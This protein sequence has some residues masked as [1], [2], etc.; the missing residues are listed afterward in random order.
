M[1][2]EID[3]ETIPLALDRL[4]RL[5]ETASNDTVAILGEVLWGPSDSGDSSRLVDTQEKK[6]LL[7]SRKLFK[8]TGLAV[9]S[10]I[11]SELSEVAQ[12]EIAEPRLDLYNEAFPLW[13]MEYLLWL[14]IHETPLSSFQVSSL[15]KAGVLGTLGYR[16]LDFYS[17][18]RVVNYR[19]ILLATY[20]RI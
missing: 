16:L 20:C 13:I 4:V 18:E 10:M 15:F 14:R 3:G 17:D 12:R 6:E 7:E 11:F 9:R 8:T 5:I 2:L 1:R 19:P